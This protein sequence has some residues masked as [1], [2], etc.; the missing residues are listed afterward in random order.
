[1]KIILVTDYFYPISNGGTEKYVYLLAKHLAPQQNIKILSVHSNLNKNSYENIAIE[2]ILP[3]TDNNKQI[4]QGIKAP[5]NIHQF[6]QYLLKEK[7]D[8][9]HFH[10]LT[11]NF[12]QHHIQI[13]HQLGIKTFFTSHIPGHICLRGDFMHLG[14]KPCDGKIEKHKCHNCL[15]NATEK[16]LIKKSIKQFFYNYS[17]NSPVKLKLTQLKSIE[18]HTSKIIAVCNWQK[19]F[20]IKNNISEKHLALCRQEVTTKVIDKTNSPKIRLGFIGRIDPVKGLEL[21]LNALKKIDISNLSLNIAAISPSEEHKAYLNKLLA[22]STPNHS[23]KFNLSNNEI[24]AFFKE[25][26]YLV[27]PSLSLETGPFVAYE[28]LA[29]NTPI[30]ATNLGGQKELIIEGENGFLFEPNETALVIKLKEI[31][32]QPIL[33]LNNTV[34]LNESN[35]AKRMQKIY[36]Q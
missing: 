4:I 5:N 9:V 27:I 8:I 16:S 19:E 23:W 7:P 12:N 1:M 3:N 32:N 13:S 21:L 14:K 10:T 18:Q 28:A 31:A 6:K 34:V 35:I 26:D 36:Q 33:S 24:D 15:A 11:T 17:N 2:Y 22:I 20:F 30:I 29:Y 25:I